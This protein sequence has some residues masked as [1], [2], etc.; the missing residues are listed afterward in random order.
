MR[1]KTKTTGSSNPMGNCYVYFLYDK[2]TKEIFY[3]GKG[4]G[5]RFLN[6]LGQALESG[7]PTVESAKE[8]NNL[9]IAYH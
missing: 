9:F 7:E 8:Q 2:L 5:D 1:K 4:E 3:V 6:H